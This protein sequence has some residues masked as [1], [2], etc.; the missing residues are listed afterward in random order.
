MHARLKVS[1]DEVE[2]QAVRAQGPGGQNVNKVSTA[3]HL[4]LDIAASS[5]PPDVKERLLALKDARVT[6]AGVIVIKVQSHRT[7]RLNREEALRRLE[8][9]VNSVARP[10]VQRRP[11]RPT[12]ASR[13]RRLESKSLHAQVKAGRE[14]VRP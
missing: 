12:M 5:L 1:P 2:I 7:Q 6:E 3:V 4:R 13:R 9:L 11:T 8:D 14:K 10:P